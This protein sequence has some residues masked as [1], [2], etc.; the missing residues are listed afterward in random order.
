MSPAFVVADAGPCLASRRGEL[1]AGRGL[2]PHSA[3][4][5]IEWT[6]KLTEMRSAAQAGVTA[7]E[8]VEALILQI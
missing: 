1:P 5:R 8:R 6:E 2:R 7:L 3:E 4:Q